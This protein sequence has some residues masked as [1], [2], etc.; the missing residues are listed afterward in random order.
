MRYLV[1][2]AC[3]CLITWSGATGADPTLPLGNHRLA[4]GDV[5]RRQSRQPGGE[6]SAIRAL[7][8]GRRRASLE[9]AGPDPFATA[10]PT[11]E[12]FF[13]PCKGRAA[14]PRPFWQRQ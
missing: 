10:E 8:R 14:A 13:E 6:T 12:G 9:R 1:V 5:D 4:G 2:S 3:L 11:H 7:P